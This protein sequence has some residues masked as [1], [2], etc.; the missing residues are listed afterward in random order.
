M[1]DQTE[2]V[3]PTPATRGRH[4]EAWVGLF[5]ILGTLVG[6]TTLFTLTDASMFRGRYVLTTLVSDAGGIRRGD[7]LVLRGVNIGRV[8]S[9][10]ISRQGVAVR[11]EVEGQY[12]VPVGSR[13]ALRQNSVLGSVYADVVPG[14]S[15]EMMKGGDT[16]P[17]ERPQGLY[18]A[19]SA[20]K[21]DAQGVLTQAK[22]ALGP[23]TVENIHAGTK[24]M[25][26]LLA[27]LRGMTG[28]Q[29]KELR[30][31]TASLKR[32]ATDVEGL[33]GRPELDRA[34]KRLD[35]LS[36]RL[37]ESTASLKRSSG[38]LETV[39][40]R[41]ERGEGT[42][43]KLSKDETLYNNLNEA[44]GNLNKLADDVRKQPKKYL[45]LSLF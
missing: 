4:R 12:K 37:D 14:E 29:R 35:T 26:Q 16:L 27:E 43:G 38:S 41:L 32:T 17:G 42:L 2:R 24:E 1:A 36:A 28:E 39:L 20:L 23:E 31:L 18:D 13:I 40:A 30:D 10:A 22:A 11:L 15:A 21:D 45:K 34:I 6:I 5:V 8:Q 7:P 25:R 44:V 3:P 33:A 9:F 19:M